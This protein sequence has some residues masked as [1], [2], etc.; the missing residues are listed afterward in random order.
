VQRLD[1]DDAVEPL[2]E[3]DT[4]AE[5]LVEQEIDRAV[6]PVDQ[7]H[8]HRAHE[9]RHH[10]RDHAERVNERGAAKTKARQDGGERHRDQ[11]RERDRHGGDIDRVPERFAQQAG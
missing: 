10:Q 2:H 6:A 4:K 9:R 7:L 11:A 8:R 1:E 3:R 5:P